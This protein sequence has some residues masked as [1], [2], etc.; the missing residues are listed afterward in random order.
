MIRIGV[1]GY[2][3]GAHHARAAACHPG[4]E[5]VQVCDLDPA[6]REQ[7]LKDFPNISVTSSADELLERTDIDV[8]SVASYDNFHVGQV[9]KALFSGKHVF[10]EKPMCL[11]R[12]ECAEI[13]DVLSRCDGL[14]LSSNLGLRTSSRFLGVKNAITAGA[15]G[16]LYHIE[17]E[18]LWGR[19][20]KLTDGW[21][22]EMPFYSIIH[23]AAVHM[24]DLV[25]W[26]TGE[27]P[28]AVKGVGSQIVTR[29]TRLKYNDFASFY[30][31]YNNGMSVMVAAHGGCVHPHF[32]R[33]A[34]YG[35]KQTFLNDLSASVWI[36]SSDPT[37]APR[38]DT[39]SYPARNQRGLILTSFLDSIS[40]SGAV[41]LVSERDI[42]DCMSICFAAEEAVEQGTKVEIEYAA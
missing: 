4:C 2:G 40:D 16:E 38:S 32:H 9:T 6:K 21:R 31:E 39:G 18:Y 15:M 28:A 25:N 30:L 5:L 8:V 42:F 14:K 20:F 24:V 37:V 29:G 3:V 35:T 41:P 34:V 23:G 22:A 17:A 13:A 10:V 33:L 7:A 19:P 12:E 1:I 11:N 36:D 27:R 26:I